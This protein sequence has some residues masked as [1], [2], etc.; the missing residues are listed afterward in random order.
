MNDRE[1]SH[2]LGTVN[3]KTNQQIDIKHESST[4]ILITHMK[5]PMINKEESTNVHSGV[6]G[7]AYISALVTLRVTCECSDIF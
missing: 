5:A 6:W 1:N 3:T 2:K 7:N 4:H